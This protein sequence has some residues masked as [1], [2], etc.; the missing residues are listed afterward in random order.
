VHLRTQRDVMLQPDGE[1]AAGH[2][3]KNMETAKNYCSL[4]SPMTVSELMDHGVQNC[5]EFIL[6]SQIEER[7]QELQLNNAM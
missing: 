3:L 7:L 1:G 6:K 4:W 5:F 2:A